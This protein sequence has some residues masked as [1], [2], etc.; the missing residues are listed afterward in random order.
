M[1]GDVEI[2][3]LSPLWRQGPLSTGARPRLACVPGC[4][5]RSG[6]LGTGGRGPGGRGEDPKTA[7]KSNVDRGPLLALVH[8]RNARITCR[9]WYNV[10]TTCSDTAQYLHTCT[11]PSYTVGTY[12]TE[13]AQHASA[14]AGA[15]R[16]FRPGQFLLVSSSS[17]SSFV[18]WQQLPTYQ[19]TYLG[20]A[21]GHLRIR[22]PYTRYLCRFYNVRLRLRVATFNTVYSWP[23]RQKCDGF[24]GAQQRELALPSRS[25]PAH[26]SVSVPARPKKL[27]THPAISRSHPHLRT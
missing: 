9:V 8:P 18:V 16:P 6:C 25:P 17:T 26:H 5:A 7:Q 24:D 27:P 4:L 11:V 12:L 15:K 14:G 1:P 20:Q 10:I 13:P 21:D 2:E 19:P 22:L 3:P 23:P